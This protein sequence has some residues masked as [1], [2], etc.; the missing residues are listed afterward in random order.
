MRDQASL[1]DASL[2]RA[3]E[4]L[5]DITAPVM[6]RF[7][8]AHPEARTAFEHHRPGCFEKLEAEMVQNALYWAM[9]WLDRAMEIR[10]HLGGSV[11]HHEETLAVP[12]TWYRGLVEAVTDVIAETIPADRPDEM[13]VWREIRTGL[14]QAINQSTSSSTKMPGLSAPASPHQPAG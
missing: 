3:A 1:L 8:D 11:P 4:A 12:A 7:Y 6:A 5:G 2:E 13:V 9:A 10:V 14:G